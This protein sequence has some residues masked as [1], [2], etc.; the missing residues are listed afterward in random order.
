MR[1]SIH[2]CA[3]KHASECKVMQITK[4]VKLTYKITYKYTTLYVF[5][6]VVSMEQLITNSTV[7]QYFIRSKYIRN[8][9][10]HLKTR[11]ALIV[12]SKCHYKSVCYVLG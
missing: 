7:M 8:I 1:K 6:S 11:N 3:K 12:P 10:I 2:F 5:I 9:K 4:T